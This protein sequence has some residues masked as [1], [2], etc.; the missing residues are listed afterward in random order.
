M[1]LKPAISAAVRA[2]VPTFLPARPQ[3]RNIHTE[4][5]AVIGNEGSLQIA[6]CEEADLFEVG[7][8]DPF[9]AESKPTLRNLGPVG[10]YATLS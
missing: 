5:R 4:K 9:A 1:E 8:D 3:D 2:A 10:H 7:L 6:V